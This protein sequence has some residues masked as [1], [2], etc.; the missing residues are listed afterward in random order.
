MVSPRTLPP[1]MYRVWLWN[2][3]TY[4]RRVDW[5]RGRI[6]TTDDLARALVL[7]ADEADALCRKLI[8]HTWFMVEMRKV[9]PEAT[10]PEGAHS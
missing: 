7:P 8:L 10:P 3:R 5:T 4:V 6:L 2:A 9:E 1:L